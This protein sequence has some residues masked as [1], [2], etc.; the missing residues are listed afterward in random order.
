[1]AEW[2][3]SVYTSGK[4]VIV[5]VRISDLATAKSHV[6]HKRA[7]DPIKP[8]DVCDLTASFVL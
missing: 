3:I 7:P 8:I 6:F 5:I 1:M 2:P 4:K